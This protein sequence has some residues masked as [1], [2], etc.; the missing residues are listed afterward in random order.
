M[1]GRLGAAFVC[2]GGRLL[3]VARRL[4]RLLAIARGI[5]EARIDAAEAIDSLL[6]EFHALRPSRS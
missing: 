4:N 5:A 1:S 2:S 3:R 6:R